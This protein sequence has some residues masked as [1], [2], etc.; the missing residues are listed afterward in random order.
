MLHVDLSIGRDD[1]AHG[2]YLLAEAGGTAALPS[3]GQCGGI[4]HHGRHMGG[5]HGE[6]VR[7]QAGGA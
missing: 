2:G 1:A 6:I 3:L 4:Y 7:R 5:V